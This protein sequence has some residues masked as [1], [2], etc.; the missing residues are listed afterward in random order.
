MDLWNP[1][2]NFK[3][4]FNYI[5][6]S[7]SNQNN[8]FSRLDLSCRTSLKIKTTS[9]ELFLIKNIKILVI[10]WWLKFCH[11]IAFSL[12]FFFSFLLIFSLFSGHP[13]TKLKKNELTNWIVKGVKKSDWIWEKWKLRDETIHFCINGTTNEWNVNF[14]H[15][16]FS[17]IFK[18]NIIINFPNS[19]G[20]LVEESSFHQCHGWTWCIELEV[21]Y[22]EMRVEKQARFLFGWRGR[23]LEAYFQLS[24]VPMQMQ[25]LCKLRELK[26]LV[27]YCF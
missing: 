13:G 27:E 19:F 21:E 14:D 25:R 4:H 2:V 3:T 16:S 22:I 8:I 17:C 23:H 20:L 7:K 10:N 6:N 5:K 24:S 1:V 26:L 12:S 18:N 11:S 9:I 15:W